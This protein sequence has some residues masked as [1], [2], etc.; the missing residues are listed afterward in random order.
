MSTYLSVKM[1]PK[2]VLAQKQSFRDYIF[3]KTVFCLRLYW[4]HFVTKVSE[5]FLNQRK[6]LDFLILI[7]AY[8]KGKK[9]TSI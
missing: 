2:K 5:H 8:L 7:L 3:L 4:V 6:I 9:L 1:H